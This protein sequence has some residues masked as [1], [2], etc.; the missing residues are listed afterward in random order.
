MLNCFK[1]ES[2]VARRIMMVGSQVVIAFAVLFIKISKSDGKSMMLVRG[3]TG[4]LLSVGHAKLEGEALFRG[5]Q[6]AAMA[7]NRGMLLAV[8]LGAFNISIKLVSMSLLAILSRLQLVVLMIASVVVQRY[9]FNIKVV[10]AGLLCLLGVMLV[11]APGLLGFGNLAENQKLAMNWSRDEIVGLVCIVFWVFWDS[12]SFLYLSKVASKMNMAE[13][14]INSHICLSIYAA[15][16]ITLTDGMP[17]LYWSDVPLYFAMSICF[18]FGLLLMTQSFRMEKNVATQ[19]IMTSVVALS[20]FVLDFLFLDT[21]FAWINWVGC[22]IILF[23]SIW[24]VL[25]RTEI[26]KKPEFAPATDE[27]KVELKEQK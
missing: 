27:T 2:V 23:A 21:R 18:Y 13:T 8:S 11:V 22:A 16:W 20:T 3:V 14:Q 17:V 15:I 4:T 1:A 26:S 6:T 9:P 24:A 7:I 19:S 12:G 25:I 10:V 5:W